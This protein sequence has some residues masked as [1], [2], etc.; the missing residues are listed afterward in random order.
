MLND[1]KL[2]AGL[3]SV[4]IPDLGPAVKKLCWEIPEML[5]YDTSY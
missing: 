4:V 3:L 1:S 2:Q 5:L